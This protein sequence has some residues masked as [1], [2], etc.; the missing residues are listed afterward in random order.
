MLI[1]VIVPI[2]NTEQY[3]SV[4]LESILKQTYKNIEV[5]LV[6]DGST[7]GSLQI[8]MNYAKND[9]RISIVRA[10]HKGLV[11][12]RKLGVEKSR[13]LYCIFVDSDDWIAENL[14]ESILPLAYNGSTDIINYNVRSVNGTKIADWK[15]TIP[16]GVYE[17][18]ELENI[19]GKMM[20]D[21]RK[22]C[23]GVIQALWTKMIKREIL[24]QSIESVDNRITLG[25]DAAVVYKAM[26]IARKIVI[27]NK[28]LYFYRIR[29]GS[30]CNSK[31]ENTFNKIFIFQQYMR[32]IFS[33][34]NKKYELNK[35]LEAY[36]TLFIN[37]GIYDSFSIKVHSL[38]RIPFDLSEM[39]KKIILY[40]TG[41]VGRSYYR[42]LVQSDNIEI[43][44]WIDK[45]AE[46][47]WL[48]Q[49]RIES[50]QIISNINFDQILIAVKNEQTAMDIR[51]KLR[52][53]VLDEQIIWRAPR[54]N[55]W[56]R[57]I[58]I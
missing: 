15:Y 9:S 19:Y 53:I 43:M 26:L 7:D 38:Y 57:E 49:R 3:I 44:A 22:G 6:D 21:L 40:G 20:F 28:Y 54:I 18:P 41:E 30:M 37:K 47:Q 45:A 36:I 17:H 29:I 10:E 16:E 46:K 23:P 35:Q 31:N 50:Y 48:Y 58:D 33:K 25:E 14:L 11:M 24:W 5:I 52:E 39:G 13:G 27:T 55:W 56:E 2:Y 34:C 51:K 32:G 4:C 42:Q 8:C 1:S 12:A